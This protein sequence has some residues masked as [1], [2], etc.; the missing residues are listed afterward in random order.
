MERGRRIREVQ[1]AQ[2]KKDR[3]AV[4]SKRTAAFTKPTPPEKTAEQLKHD[5]AIA[6]LAKEDS[7]VITVL[8]DLK[9][10]KKKEKEGEK[11]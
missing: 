5:R 9:R 3:K 10:L 4:H 2:A 1:R 7:A 6:K 8:E 11:A